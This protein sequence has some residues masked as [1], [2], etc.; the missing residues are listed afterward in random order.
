MSTCRFNCAD[1]PF[2]LSGA[3]SN[4]GSAVSTATTSPFGLWQLP[5]AVSSA[6]VAA[7]NAKVAQFSKSTAALAFQLPE[8]LFVYSKKSCHAKISSLRMQ[9]G[10]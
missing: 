2:Q 9:A 1:L 8:L 10:T 6:T 3:V 5:G 7:T 4:C